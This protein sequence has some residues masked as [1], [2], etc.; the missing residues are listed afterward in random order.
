M[1]E[2]SDENLPYII[3]VNESN[4]EEAVLQASFK[5]PVMVDFWAPWCNPCKMLMPI[6]TKLAEE[7]EGK[8]ILAKVNVDENQPLA[9][10]FNA[11]S[12]PAVKIFRNGAVVDE[13]MGAQPESNVRKVLDNH[14]E[15]ASDQARLEASKLIQ[16]GDLDDAIEL[17][18]KANRDDPDNP[19]VRS[20]LIATLFLLED[21]DQVEEAIKALPA[22][23]Q[24]AD[25]IK[26]LKNRLLFAKITVKAADMDT[27]KSTIAQNPD[28]SEARY[29][30]AA[31]LVMEGGTEE[32][33]SELL[34]LLMRDRNYGDDA[35][36]KA[37]LA[38]LDSMGDHTTANQWRRKIAN[39][40]L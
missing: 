37:M 19:R 17:L 28:N 18:R 25:E 8:F 34:I 7:F 16:Q 36:R 35:A 9:T 33:L 5:V 11:R 30:Y 1:N 10:Q 23:E 38:I 24:E 2:S 12:V 15:R 22:I 26:G 29:Q 39:T 3:D 14:I 21:Y 40:I 6:V 32:G 4:F 27:L 20:D 31:R 13:F